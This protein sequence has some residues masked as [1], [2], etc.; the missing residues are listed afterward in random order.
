[1][2][3]SQ[4][5]GARAARYAVATAAL[6]IVGAAAV[7]AFAVLQPGRAEEDVAE[8]FLTALFAGQ[9]V[10]AYE[11]TSPSYRALVLPEELDALSDAL[12]RVAGDGVAIRVLGSERTPGSLPLESLVGYTG[13]TAVGTVEGVVTLFEIEGPWRVAD[14][15]FEFVEAPP[16]RTAELR[17][18]TRRLNEQVEERAGVTTTPGG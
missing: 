14:V 1:M 2:L 4:T 9:G 18:L 8:R 16:E 6:A 17:D 12:A 11:L 7:F 15:S 5:S 3:R 10:E 13:T